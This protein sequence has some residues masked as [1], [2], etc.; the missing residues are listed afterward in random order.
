MRMCNQ[1]SAEIVR[2]VSGAAVAATSSATSMCS[3]SD[4]QTADF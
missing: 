1:Q 2:I 3:V 4:E